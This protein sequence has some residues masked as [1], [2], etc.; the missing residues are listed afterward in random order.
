MLVPL[1]GSLQQ[2]QNYGELPEILQS[3]I[4]IFSNFPVEKQILYSLLFVIF[5]VVLKNIFLAVS[6]YLAYWLTVR[7][8]AT[9]RGQIINT[10]M[11][12]SIGYYSNVKTGDLVEKVS[13]NTVLIEEIIKTATELLDYLASF[14]VLLALLVIFS[15]KLT[16]I[17]IVLA[18]II[19]L[20][21]SLHIKN[22]PQSAIS[23]SI[24]Q[25]T[26]RARCTR[27]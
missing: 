21:L 18:A 13:Y 5:A 10:L 12:V 14:L 4:K 2:V 11:S 7:M 20:A 23:T 19:A 1:L 26:L 17:T 3:L 24:A 16:L 6:H 27:A 8:T 22:Y 15:L 9:L 25:E